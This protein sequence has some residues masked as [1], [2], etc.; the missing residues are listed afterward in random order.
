MAGDVDAVG[1]DYCVAVGVF[2]LRPLGRVVLDEG[3]RIDH[4]GP[5]LNVEDA[6]AAVGGHVEVQVVAHLAGEAGHQEVGQVVA[7]LEVQC[8]DQVGHRCV[9]VVVLGDQEEPVGGDDLVVEI[10]GSLDG[11]AAAVTVAE[12]QVGQSV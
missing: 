1:T 2:L 3:D 5:W 12:H 7:V 9:G 8:G 11:T 10:D 6:V 4:C